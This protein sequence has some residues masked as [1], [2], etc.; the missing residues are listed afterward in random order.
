MSCPCPTSNTTTGGADIMKYVVKVGNGFI[1]RV[2]DN[3]DI[4]LTLAWE[5]AKQCDDLTHAQSCAETYGGTVYKV[6]RSLE[7]VEVDDETT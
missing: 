2:D 5:L 4:L 1:K 7:P 3:G 6:T